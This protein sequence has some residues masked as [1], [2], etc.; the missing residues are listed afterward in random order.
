MEKITYYMESFTN[1]VTNGITLETTIMALSL[2]LA[3]TF[4]LT[5]QA[6]RGRASAPQ[7][8]P[9]ADTPEN[10]N[11][12][13]QLKQEVMRLRTDLMQVHENTPR[14]ALERYNP[15]KDS[16]VGGNQSFSLA[17]VNKKGDGFIVTHLF[18]REMSRVQTKAITNWQSD[19]ELSPEEKATL[20]KL[21]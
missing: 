14:V 13:E 9:I 3:I 2:G 15:F 19:L 18:S 20:E 6:L 8:R 16:G 21:Q 4:L 1:A 10:Q 7:S 17:S 5:L 11:Q 12:L